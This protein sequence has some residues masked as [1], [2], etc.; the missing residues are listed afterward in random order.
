[1]VVRPRLRAGKFA[2][3]SGWITGQTVTSRYLGLALV[4]AAL[5]GALTWNFTSWNFGLPT[6][7]SHA[8]VG[9]LVGAGLT[10]GGL[11]AIKASSTWCARCTGC[12]SGSP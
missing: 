10:A 4:F 5:L 2:R 8:L 1:V 3:S 11:A 6:S 9:G 12:R 7:S